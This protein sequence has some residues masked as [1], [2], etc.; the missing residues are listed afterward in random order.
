MYVRMR[1]RVCVQSILVAQVWQ[2]NVDY[3][4]ILQAKCFTGENIPIYSITVPNPYNLLSHMG[5]V[6]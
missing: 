5:R 3:M 1:S 4:K 6:K 2:R